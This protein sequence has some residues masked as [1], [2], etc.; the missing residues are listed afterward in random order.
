MDERE[1]HDGYEPVPYWAPPLPAGSPF[2]RCY[3]GE[4][5]CMMT[6]T[7]LMETT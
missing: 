4:L 2:G 3:G 1:L 6:L 7:I 5:P